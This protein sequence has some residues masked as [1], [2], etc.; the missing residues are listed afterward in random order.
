MIDV[1]YFDG[2]T[3]DDQT[4]TYSWTGTPHASTSTR[5]ATPGLWVEAFVD[6][7]VPSVGITVTGL[8]ED[9]VSRVTVWRSTEGNK[10]RIVRG[11]NERKVFGGDFGLDYEVPLGRLVTYDIVVQGAIIP[12]RLTDSVFVESTVGYIQDQLLPLGAVPVSS[13]LDLDNAAVLT[14]TA[15]RKWKTAVDSS[16]VSVLGRNEPVAMTGQRMAMSGVDFSVFTE[17]AEQSSALAALL[18]STPMVLIR[19]LPSWGPLPD[20]IYTVP[21]VSRELVYGEAGAT[22]T[23]WD[24]SGDQMAPQSI[25]VL[26]SL[27]T[28]GDVEAL[29]A[30]YADA[31][32]AAVASGATY[33]AD[34]RDPTMGV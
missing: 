8:A 34:Q 24:L 31:Q 17:A 22:M 11:W 14:N 23:T 13:G 30:T 21:E 27:W 25:Q 20:L 19:P 32:A 4:Y 1:P 29:W 6:T 26:V 33:L 18:E 12:L 2:D 16:S 10:R 5:S 9:T 28:Y 7:P 3:P 15:F